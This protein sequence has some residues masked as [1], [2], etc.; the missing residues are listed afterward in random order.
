MECVNARPAA[1]LTLA[2]LAV[3]GQGTAQEPVA[4]VWKE[5]TLF[6]PYRSAVVV[7]TCSALEDRVARILRGVGARP[8]LEVR[9]SN[10]S[11]S[12]PLSDPPMSDS[13]SW[14]A[15]GVGSWGT[16]EPTT[17]RSLTRR[18][19]PQQV[20]NVRV[21]LM[22]PVEVT[23]E[24]LEELKKDR[25]RRELVSRVTGDPAAR[26]ADPIPFTAQRQLVTLSRKTIG[27][28]PEE[29]ELLDQMSASGFRELGIR[30][31]RRGFV[32][33]PSRISRIAPELE[34]EAL[35]VTSFESSTAHPAPPH[36]APELPPPGQPAPAQPPSETAPEQPGNR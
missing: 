30:V 2:L 4:A 27:L 15:D 26:F 24:V 20:V 18:T 31:V 9:V 36:P 3:T 22:M 25:S 32:C 28:E 23:P 11:E 17:N 8:D 1:L 16:L 19:E 6:F 12:I 14:G 34:V 33:D 10:C 21:S 35:I 5:R 7:Y 13:G 29:C